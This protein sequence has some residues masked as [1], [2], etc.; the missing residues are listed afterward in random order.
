MP[1]AQKA[2]TLDFADFEPHTPQDAALHVAN[3]FVPDER[4]LAE[5]ADGTIAAFDLVQLDS[6]TDDRLSIAALPKAAV[7][8]R[9]GRVLDIGNIVMSTLDSARSVTTI[10]RVAEV[11]PWAAAQWRDGFYRVGSMGLRHLGID[12]RRYDV[13][14]AASDGSVEAE[15]PRRYF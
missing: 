8:P 13:T 15:A 2:G 1:A 12:A 6:A 7:S 9:N 10:H 4:G 14:E 11:L 5:L 3:G